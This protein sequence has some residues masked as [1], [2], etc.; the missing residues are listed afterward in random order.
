M[1][2]DPTVRWQA[3]PSIIDGIAS[4]M[5]VF[6]RGLWRGALHLIV[7]PPNPDYRAYGI[8]VPCECYAG[9]EEMIYS[10]TPHGDTTANYRGDTYIKEA[11][12]SALITAFVENDPFQRKPRHYLF[13]GGGLL[14]R[15]AQPFGAC[16]SRVGQSRRRLRMATLEVRSGR[17]AA[18]HLSHSHSIVPGG[19]LVMSYT[20]RF[21]P[22]TSL[23]MR[24]AVSPKNFMSNA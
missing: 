3:Y 12:Q 22:F 13:V 18:T 23:M 20:T 19:L 15:G 17:N 10:V 16:R 11:K 5:F 6:D 1:F 7:V 9:F 8:E 4:P 21:T 24:V 2:P 14:L